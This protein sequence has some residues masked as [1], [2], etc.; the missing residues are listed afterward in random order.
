MENFDL[1]LA[2]GHIIFGGFFF[3]MG[4]SHF[5]K[6]E[7]LSAYA[8]SKKVWQPKIAVYVS[9]SLI[10]VGGLG[11][12]AGRFVTLSSLLIL[13]FLV[14]I[15]FSM[16]AFWKEKDVQVKMLDQVQ[17]LKNTALIGAALILLA[18]SL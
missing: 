14:P 15:T 1:I 11:I 4:L 3:L 2:L 6:N 9:G 8:A 12:I 18:H 10:L 13:A 16:H 17:F 7:S 5:T